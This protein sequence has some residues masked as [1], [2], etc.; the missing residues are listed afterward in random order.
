[1]D[2]ET[3]LS[4]PELQPLIGLLEPG[5]GGFVS[6]SLVGGSLH[7][8]NLAS[9]DGRRADI[10]LL[11]KYTASWII[12]NGLQPFLVPPNL[13][14][15]EVAIND[16][17]HPIRLQWGE[18]HSLDSVEREAKECTFGNYG[19]WAQYLTGTSVYLDLEYGLTRFLPGFVLFG[20][21]ACHGQLLNR[22]SGLA[23][24]VIGVSDRFIVWILE[25]FA[26]IRRAGTIIS[27]TEIFNG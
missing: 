18:L 2:V 6:I 15:V 13:T 5:P 16:Q 22:I 14:S 7:S 25:Q 1:M 21:S 20:P 4:S 17:E 19:L 9:S 24:K 26:G 23:S 10:E 27:R 3:R 8:V 12:D 11:G